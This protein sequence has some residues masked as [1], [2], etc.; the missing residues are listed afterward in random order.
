MFILSKHVA[1]GTNAASGC[2]N[3]E[4]FQQKLPGKRSHKTLASGDASANCRPS[5]ISFA[6][7]TLTAMFF[8]RSMFTLPAIW[9]RNQSRSMLPSWQYWS[10]TPTSSTSC[11]LASTRYGGASARKRWNWW[12]WA[13]TGMPRWSIWKVRCRSA[14]CCFASERHLVLAYY[15]LLCHLISIAILFSPYHTSVGKCKRAAGAPSPARHNGDRAYEG[16]RR[17]A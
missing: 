17:S 1:A 10:A 5:C 2:R 3:C 13:A 8:F 7:V 15:Y 12:A 9:I 14:C 4:S 6:I 16:G 11:P